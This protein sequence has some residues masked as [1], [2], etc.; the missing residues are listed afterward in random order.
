MQKKA[1]R[2]L[3]EVQE[4]RDTIAE[5][6][7]KIVDAEGELDEVRAQQKCVEAE[8]RD[9]AVPGEGEVPTAVPLHERLGIP[10][11]LFA[12]PEVLAKQAEIDAAFLLIEQLRTAA[13]AA[14]AAEE[15]QRARQ[16]QVAA[17]RLAAEAQDELM[18]L[19]FGDP[20]AAADDADAIER[21]KRFAEKLQAIMAKRPKQSG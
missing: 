21:R 17:D 4:H 16:T 2:I 20:G 13:V 14:A 7:G 11:A 10:K 8:A 15:E 18:G 1:E 12:R 9:C 6:Q 3:R 19:A 5:L